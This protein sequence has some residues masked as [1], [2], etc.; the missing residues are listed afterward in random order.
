MTYLF[1]ILGLITLIL[2]GDLL[3][4][5]ATTIALRA[6]ISPLVIGMTVVSFGTSAPELLVSLKS[7]LNDHPDVAIGAVVGSN[8]SNIGLVLGI[9]ILLFPLIVNRDSLIIDWPMM[10]ISAILYYFFANNGII[11]QLEGVIFV[12]L[13]VIFISWIIYRSRKKGKKLALEKEIEEVAEV[14]KNFIF[15]DISFIVLG[16]LGLYFGAE[17]L[18]NSVVSIAKDFEI[19]E[20]LVSITVVAFG[21]SVPELTTSV[22]AAFKKETDI[23]IGNL[24][25][26]NIFNIL[27]ILGITGIIH[28]IAISDSINEFD[29]YFLLGITV[30]LFPLMYF[31]KKMTYRSALILL[32]IYVIYIYFSIIAEI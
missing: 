24:I 16:I 8:I 18:I 26:S 21:T 9:T 5:G 27:A 14:K 15:K 1:L 25:G 6:K 30:I 17:W 20:K 7:V 19:S 29:N 28:P 31:G 11:S 4:R 22:V 12:I 10:L 23:S 13:L 3:V 32:S 2:G